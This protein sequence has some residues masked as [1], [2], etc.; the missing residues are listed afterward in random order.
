MNKKISTFSWIIGAIVLAIFLRVVFIGVFKVPTITMAP[1]LVAGDFIISNK[2]AY[3]IKTKKPARG[4]V[5]VF[6]RA[7]KIGQYFIKIVVAIS[8]DKVAIHGGELQI[9]GEKCTYVSEQKIENFEIF[10]ET[11][12]NS[13]RRI[14]RALTGEL[15]TQ[16]LPEI[17]LKEGEFYVLGD[18]RDASE[19]SRD[20]GA[21]HTD[22]VSG[23]AQLIWLSIGSTQDSISKE[24]GFRFSRFLTKIQ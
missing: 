21:I 13:T 12:L 1:T 23:K 22:Q 11:C 10:S 4:D 2:L 18:N 24:K 8:G 9:N 7:E 19:D 14:L 6:T 5:V 3:G 20:W 16:D 17:T 15:K